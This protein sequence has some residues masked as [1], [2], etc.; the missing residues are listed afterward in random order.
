[1]G[2]S[3]ACLL[4]ILSVVSHLCREH[5][6]WLL[7]G[8]LLDDIDLVFVQLLLSTCCRRLEFA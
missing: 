1:M 7:F 2:F 6:D 4:W 3:M 8:T 5:L